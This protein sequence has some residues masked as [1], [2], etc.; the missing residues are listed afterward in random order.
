MPAI[1]RLFRKQRG[2]S[3]REY[4]VLVNGTGNMLLLPLWYFWS[5]Q[6]G[7]RDGV[8]IL[9]ASPS[10]GESFV[11]HTVAPFTIHRLR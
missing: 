2:V 5:L 8:Y 1:A 6:Y 7:G 3:F 4:I 11:K 10:H 9:G